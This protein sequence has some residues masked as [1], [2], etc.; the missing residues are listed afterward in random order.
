MSA[1]SR[2]RFEKAT[3]TPLRTRGPDDPPREGDAFGR[4]ALVRSLEVTPT[5]LSAIAAQVDDPEMKSAVEAIAAAANATSGDAVLRAAAALRQV[6]RDVLARFGQLLRDVRRR[7]V[8]DAA[9]AVATLEAKFATVQAAPALPAAPAAQLVAPATSAPATG[10][11]PAT[12]GPLAPFATS[13]AVVSARPRTEVVAGPFEATKTTIATARADRL[14]AAIAWARDNDGA[15]IAELARTFSAFGSASIS[16]PLA[17]LEDEGRRDRLI[18]LFTDALT[19]RPL[20]P[21]GVLHLERL[22]ML[23]VEI[24]RG[25]LV[26]SLPLAPLEKVTLAHRVW[27]TRE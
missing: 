20:E 15:S 27:A 17:V 23:P 10:G 8:A 13:T 12:D 24:E 3:Y 1:N 22:E 19:R 2:R 6:S 7:A 5:E 4:A 26:Y 14:R 25:E 16:E 21:L 11:D 9:S 18:D